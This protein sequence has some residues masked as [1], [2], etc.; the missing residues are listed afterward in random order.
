MFCIKCAVFFIA[1]V[2]VCCKLAKA[3]FLN[4][5]PYTWPELLSVQLSKEPL[6]ISKYQQVSRYSV[7]KHCPVS[8]NL[9]LENH[10]FLCSLADTL[11]FVLL[12]LTVHSL[13]AWK[14]LSFKW[15]TKQWNSQ[16]FFSLRNCLKKELKFQKLSRNTGSAE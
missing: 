15:Q 6:V 12:F 11:S 8:Q 14:L 10:V 13:H 2:R 5:I 16:V 3:F 7:S 9:L 1:L 4:L